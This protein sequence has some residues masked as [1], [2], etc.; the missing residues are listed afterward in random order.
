VFDAIF[1]AIQ[2]SKV[3]VTLWPWPLTSGSWT[4]TAL[5]MSSA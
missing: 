5:R 3:K 2:M 4:F 1:D